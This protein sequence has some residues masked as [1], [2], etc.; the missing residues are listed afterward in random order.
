MCR[1]CTMQN[2]VN[3]M[4]WG[5]NTVNKMHWCWLPKICWHYDVIEKIRDLSDSIDHTVNEIY[6]KLLSMNICT[7]KTVHSIYFW[8]HFYLFILHLWLSK[9]CHPLDSPVICQTIM[10]MKHNS[11][12]RCSNW[13]GWKISFWHPPRKNRITVNTTNSGV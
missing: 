3:L 2:F 12:E 6:K 9:T 5:V 13:C 4:K 8:H 10:H 7:L 1:F 11:M